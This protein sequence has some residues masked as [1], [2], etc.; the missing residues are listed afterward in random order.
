MP[1]VRDLYFRIQVLSSLFS[2]S[3]YKCKFRM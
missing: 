3:T 1:L 2:A